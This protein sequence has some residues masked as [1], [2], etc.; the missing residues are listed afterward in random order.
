[1]AKIRVCIRSGPLVAC[2][3]NM[4]IIEDYPHAHEE[5]VERVSSIRVGYIDHENRRILNYLGK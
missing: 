3:L 2:I 4:Q 5:R 1:M